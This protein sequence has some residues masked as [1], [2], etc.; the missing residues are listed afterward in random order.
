MD[1][2]DFDIVTTSASASAASTVSLALPPHMRG[3]KKTSLDNLVT[4]ITDRLYQETNDPLRFNRSDAMIGSNTINGT[5]TKTRGLSWPAAYEI[6]CN[7][8]ATEFPLF[9]I[10]IHFKIPN[11]PQARKDRDLKR[12]YKELM[13]IL[14]PPLKRR[15]LEACDNIDKQLEQK[16]IQDAAAKAEN[17]RRIIEALREE[18]R[19][20]KEA[21]KAEASKPEVIT[22]ESL[23][24]ALADLDLGEWD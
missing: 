5:I 21:E 6:A 16:R 9:R 8:F 22:H 18:K 10:Q 11:N 20:E 24:S 23:R 13:K 15:F 12:E 14:G 19:A 4:F 7:L 1:D 3:L 17:E 2:F